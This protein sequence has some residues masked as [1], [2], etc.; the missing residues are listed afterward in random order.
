MRF[1]LLEIVRD[2][3]T[4]ARVQIIALK[5]ETPWSH[6]PEYA[7]D[8]RIVF[9]DSFHPASPIGIGYEENVLDSQ[10][11]NFAPCSHL[12]SKILPGDTCPHGFGRNWELCPQC[13]SIR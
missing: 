8:Y 4:G 13:S 2:N 12:E 5:P 6:L 10:L 9:V 1:R 3:R 11:E 7:T